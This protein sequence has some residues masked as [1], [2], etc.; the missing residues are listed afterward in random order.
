MKQSYLMG[1]DIG[2]S[3][4]KVAV[5]DRQGQVLASASGDYPVY[6]PREG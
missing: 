2:T 6:Y 1:I 4:C 3:A 5:F